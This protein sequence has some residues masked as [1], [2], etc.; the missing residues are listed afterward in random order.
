MEPGAVH[1]TRQTVLCAARQPDGPQPAGTRAHLFLHFFG[2]RDRLALEDAE[3]LLARLKEKQKTA[4][5]ACDRELVPLGNQG[6]DTGCHRLNAYFK[7]YCARLDKAGLAPA[8]AQAPRAAQRARPVAGAVRAVIHAGR[9]AAALLRGS[10][11][12]L[13]LYAIGR[14]VQAGGKRRLTGRA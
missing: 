2:R 5:A 6:R 9:R 1:I 14:F 8:A 11:A 3:R 12:G 10:F 4:P 13:F 7:L